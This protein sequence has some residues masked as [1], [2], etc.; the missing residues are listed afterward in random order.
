MRKFAIMLGCAALFSVGAFA[1]GHHYYHI[2][3]RFSQNGVD[4]Q[5]FSRDRKQCLDATSKRRELKQEPIG[6]EINTG[7]GGRTPSGPGTVVYPVPTYDH[8]AV[9][10]YQCMS[11]KGYRTDPNGQFTVSFSTRL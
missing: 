4:D 5:S 8:N 11:A 1:A 3:I 2:N 10:F 9:A 7:I 6:A